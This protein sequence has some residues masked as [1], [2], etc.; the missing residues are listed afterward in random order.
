VGVFG[1]AAV[2][3]LGYAVANNTSNGRFEIGPATGW[4]LYARVARFANCSHF[5]PPAGTRGLCETRPDSQRPGNDYYI[6][7]PESPA[8]RLFR[9]TGSHD[10][11][12][13]AFALD[14]IIHQPRAYLRTV[15]HE[16]EYYF[17]PSLSPTIAEGSEGLSPQL[18]W[19][20]EP[21]NPPLAFL[22]RIKNDMQSFFHRFSIHQSHDGLVFLHRYEQTFR[23][24]GTLLS[25]TTLL[26]LLGL[27]VGGRRCRLGV[28]LFGVGGLAMLVGP[29]FATY[30][31]GR[32]SMPLAGPMF[33]AAS[34]TVLS[35]VRMERARRHLR[36]GQPSNPAAML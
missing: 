4:H 28:F 20:T 9:Y 13:K 27:F 30:Y 25:I 5:T 21:N 12:L 19:R 23:F 14:V 26:T 16:V 29:T 8:F 10:D 11:K 15:L 18:D 35:L 24:G 22:L 31:E 3:L 33:A 17:V 2:L 6:H 34:I 32:Y 7:D 36:M 1:I